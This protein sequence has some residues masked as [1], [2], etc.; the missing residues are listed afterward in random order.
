MGKTN[1]RS[2][3]SK[4]KKRKEKEGKKSEREKKK[5]EKGL[6]SREKVI[7]VLKGN[8]KLRMVAFD[9]SL[10]LWL[11][12]LAAVMLLAE[13]KKTA[14]HYQEAIVKRAAAAAM[15]TEEGNQ[16]QQQQHGRA[17]REKFVVDDAGG[18]TMNDDD[19]AIIFDVKDPGTVYSD[20]V[21]K[22]IS[23]TC[24]GDAHTRPF[25]TAILGANMGGHMVL[26]PWITVRK[27]LASVVLLNTAKSSRTRFLLSFFYFF[28]DVTALFILSIY[29]K[30]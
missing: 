29:W 27:I 5:T 2:F 21:A 12:L 19:D 26:E 3:P 17:V 30:R 7:T 24:T 8:T 13:A 6:Y 4:I 14:Y 18:F 28:F 23:M 9:R 25:N 20:F 1:L 15:V 22:N 10:L 16:Q 11:L